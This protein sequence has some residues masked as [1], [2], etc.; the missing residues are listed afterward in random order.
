MTENYLGTKPLEGKLNFRSTSMWA[1]RREKLFVETGA[2]PP[3]RYNVYSIVKGKN[4]A[5]NDKSGRNLI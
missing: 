2:Y 1:E 5:P 3:D 4:C